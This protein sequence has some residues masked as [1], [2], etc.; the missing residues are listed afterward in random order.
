MSLSKSSISK[1]MQGKTKFSDEDIAQLV[2]VFG[3]SADY[4]MARDD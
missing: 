3:L 2:E 4:L 1:K